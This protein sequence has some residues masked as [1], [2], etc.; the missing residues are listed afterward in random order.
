MNEWTSL[1]AI[2]GGI[3]GTVYHY[4]HLIAYGD[5]PL[6]KFID[7]LGSISIGGFVGA[8]LA[9]ALQAALLGLLQG[10]TI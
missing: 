10:H 2:L 5:T 9:M 6:A 3:V 4:K 1:V 8:I 7:I